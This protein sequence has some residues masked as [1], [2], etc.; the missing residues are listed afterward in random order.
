MGIPSE[1]ILRVPVINKRNNFR[2]TI[3]Q[4]WFQYF[5]SLKDWKLTLICYICLEH[6]AEECFDRVPSYVGRLRQNQHE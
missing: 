6:F 1:F 2:N 5:R 3:N 4:I